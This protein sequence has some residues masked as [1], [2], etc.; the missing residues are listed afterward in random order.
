MDSFMKLAN[1]GGCGNDNAAQEEPEATVQKEPESYPAPPSLGHLILLSRIFNQY[2]KIANIDDYAAINDW[3]KFL[4]AHAKAQMEFSDRPSDGRFQS[5]WDRHAAW[6]R[7][8]FGP[9]VR[10]PV[11]PLKHLQKEADE[12]FANPFD[13]EEKADILLLL[14]DATRTSGNTLSDLLTAAEEKLEKNRKRV[15]A[16]PD[17]HG[18]FEH[19][20]SDVKS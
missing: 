5:F 17:E 14:I 7:S 12:A 15:W 8:A 16:K 13:L 1:D 2:Q 11:G 9:D 20:R 3:L 4:I 18:C 19:I 6:S 10:G